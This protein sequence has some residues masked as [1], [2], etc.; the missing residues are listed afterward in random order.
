MTKFNVELT[1]DFRLTADD[2]NFIVERCVV[3]DPTKAP[4]WAARVAKDPSLS[5]EPYESWREDGG[6]YPLTAVGLTAAI[7]NA[8]IR[9]AVRPEAES[10]AEFFGEIREEM[11]KVT[12]AVD[13][14]LTPVPP[15]KA[16]LMMP[17]YEQVTP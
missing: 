2:R 8:I 12:A 11:R 17:L 16:V 10:L 3:V 13:A 6:Y 7:Q 9:S 5:T 1:Q 4:N 14:L 15:S